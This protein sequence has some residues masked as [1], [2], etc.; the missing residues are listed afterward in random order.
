MPEINMPS[1]ENKTEEMSRTLAALQEQ[2]TQAAPTLPAPT[3]ALTR[4][5]PATTI[6]FHSTSGEAS[7]S[8]ASTQPITSAYS[9]LT[10]I[11]RTA[12]T[13]ERSSALRRIEMIAGHLN[14][15]SIGTKIK[16]NL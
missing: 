6:Q 3:D 1:K 9:R 10:E 5:L 11:L 2:L 12:T 14:Q 16:S 7:S 15:P 8:S 4:Q 13:E